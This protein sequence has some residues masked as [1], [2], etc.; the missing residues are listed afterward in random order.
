MVRELEF[1]SKD[2]NLNIEEAIYIEWTRFFLMWATSSLTKFMSVGALKDRV[3]TVGKI[4]GTQDRKLKSSGHIY[5]NSGPPWIFD[6]VCF[7]AL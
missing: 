7:V 2:P 4:V 3:S 6:N 1:S 5:E